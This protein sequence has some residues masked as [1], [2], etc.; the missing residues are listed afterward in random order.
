MNILKL[1]SRMR[2]IRYIL[3][4]IFEEL[5]FLWKRIGIYINYLFNN[6]GPF[7]DNLSICAIIKNEVDYLEEWIEFHR[8]V[9]VTKFYIYDNHS[10][11]GTVEILRSYINKGIVVAKTWPK[12]DKIDTTIQIHAYNDAI[13]ICKNKTRWLALIDVDEFIV[14]VKK[15]SICDVLDE[16][17]LNHCCLHF[18]ICFSFCH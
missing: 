16:I 3:G 11:D 15:N 14:P 9:G 6:K 13:K 2:V 1:G 5:L 17:F 18:I 8:L 10:N 7:E 4:Y 12:N